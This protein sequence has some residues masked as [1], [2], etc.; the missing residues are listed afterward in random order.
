MNRYAIIMA[1]G[2]GTRLFPISTRNKPKQF[3]DLFGNGIFIWNTYTI[4][5]AFLDFMPQLYE[6]FQQIK[7]YFKTDLFYEKLE[8]IYDIIEPHPIKTEDYNN[9][10]N[11]FVQEVINTGIKVA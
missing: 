11:P 10:D 3:L 4:K 6:K 5:R 7:K 9:I 8:K 1:G 2:D